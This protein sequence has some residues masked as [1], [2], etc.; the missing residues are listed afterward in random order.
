MITNGK[1]LKLKKKDLENIRKSF[2]ISWSSQNQK[3]CC[4]IT[5]EK[6][7]MNKR[8]RMSSGSS[9]IQ[10]GKDTAQSIEVLE[11]R[12]SAKKFE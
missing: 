9:C 3:V 7:V 11:E 6:L 4:E 8:D 12:P 5:I 1:L 2:K 10:L